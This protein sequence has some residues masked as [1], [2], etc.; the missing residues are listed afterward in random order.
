VIELNGQP[1]SEGIVIGKAFLL[2][3][4][5]LKIPIYKIKQTEVEKEKAKFL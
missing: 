1:S 2:M 5:F 4:D 3:K